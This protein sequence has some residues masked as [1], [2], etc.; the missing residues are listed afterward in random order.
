MRIESIGHVNSLSAA[1]AVA[2]GGCCV[3][4][5]FEPGEP[6]VCFLGGHMLSGVLVLAPGCHCVLTQAPVL[7][8]HKPRRFIKAGCFALN[9]PAC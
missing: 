7:V 6:S 2:F 4:A 9:Q 3:F 1:S 5:C 8:Q